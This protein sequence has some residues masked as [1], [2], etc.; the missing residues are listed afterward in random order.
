MRHR[1]A[2]FLNFF[3]PWVQAI[4]NGDPNRAPLHRCGICDSA[5]RKALYPHAPIGPHSGTQSASCNCQSASSWCTSWLSIV[6]HLL[7]F[8]YA[9]LYYL[10]FAHY[11]RKGPYISSLLFFLFLYIYNIYYKSG[12]KCMVQWT[13]LP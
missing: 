5:I 10:F 3:T 4:D 11:R 6:G 8:E 1:W 12:G 2:Q 9:L 13:S 7:V